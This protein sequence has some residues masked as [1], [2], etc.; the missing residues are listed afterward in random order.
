MASFSNLDIV[1]IISFFAA[2]ML[3]GFFARTKAKTDSSDFLLSGRRVGLFLFVMTNVSTWY[4][5]ILGV[6]EFTYN[7]GLLSWVTQGLPYYLFALLFAFFFAEKIQGS[8]L[9]TI[10]DKLEI[11]YGKK[12]G[13]I[14]S[15][16]ILILVTPAPYILMT[17]NL[18]QLIFNFDLL[19]SLIIAT[20]FSSLYL[21]RGG[22]KADLFTD[23]FQFFVM[24]L[25][26]IMIVVLSIIQFDGISFLESK[27]PE[28]HLKLFGGASPYFIIVWFLI[29]AWTFADPG[30][31]QRCNAAKDGKTAKYGILISI[32]F[33]I[34]FD[35]LTTTTGLFSR[36]ALPNID[37]PVQAFPLY[38][39]L[40]LSSGTK[41]IFYAALFATII[42]T[43]N[44]F[45]FIS[46]TTFGRDLVFKLSK[47]KNEELIVRYTKYGIIISSILSIILAYSVKSVINIWYLVGSVFIPGLIILII[48]SYYDKFRI[49]N[50]LATLEIIT[51]SLVSFLWI[52]IRKMWDSEIT[53]NIE[54][55]IVGL[56]SAIIIHIYGL[57]K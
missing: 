5:G 15:I 16:F 4:G 6:G 41:G 43:T 32:F 44:S 39:E 26:F 24:F 51:A 34:L 30:F 14:S 3:I 29:A 35:F 36:A 11:S 49:S 38:A 40:I 55:M 57:R 13:L 33:W 50:R 48:S 19:T 45:L 46:A 53:L 8:S 25:G 47:T 12:V 42:S 56:L 27:L 20:I 31:H 9:F 7:S 21:L 1:I 52:I 2:L 10:P 22:Y 23:V 18:I 54:P 17:G 28:N 37:N